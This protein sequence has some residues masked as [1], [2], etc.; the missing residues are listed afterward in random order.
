MIPFIVADAPRMQE[1]QGDCRDS[2]GGDIP[3]RN[4]QFLKI[5]DDKE[6]CLSLCS[7][8]DGAIGCEFHKIAAT[9]LCWAV[10]SGRIAGGSGNADQTCWK[11][12]S[13]NGESPM[14]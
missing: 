3:Q 2:N 4:L 7:Q 11:F 14:I 5:D 8:V 13:S 12:G 6:V 10:L 1:F 9:G